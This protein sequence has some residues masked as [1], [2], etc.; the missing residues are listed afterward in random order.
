VLVMRPGLSGESCRGQIPE[1][2]RINENDIKSRHQIKSPWVLFAIEG[3]GD[4]TQGK[5]LKFR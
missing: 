5:I 3:R 2:I 4:R 1:V